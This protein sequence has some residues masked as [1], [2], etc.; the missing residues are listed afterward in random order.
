MSN[1]FEDFRK[2]VNEAMKDERQEEYADQ[3][4]EGRR[5]INAATDIYNSLRQGKITREQAIERINKEL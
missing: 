4:R 2:W 1:A 5:K 3:A